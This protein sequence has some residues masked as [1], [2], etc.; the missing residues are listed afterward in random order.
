MERTKPPNMNIGYPKEFTNINIKSKINDSFISSKTPIS[1]TRDLGSDKVAK[2]NLEKKEISPV[3]SYNELK[4]KAKEKKSVPQV[5]N[6][7]DNILK[8]TI[9]YNIPNK[10]KNR[11]LE[12][13]PSLNISSNKNNKINNFDLNK[14]DKI[15]NVLENE[16]KNKHFPNKHNSCGKNTTN[17][18]NYYKNKYNSTLNNNDK[19]KQI[20]INK[21]NKNSKIKKNIIDFNN[22]DNMQNININEERSNQIRNK[23]SN[24]LNYKMNNNKIK[25]DPNLITKS[26]MEDDDIDDRIPFKKYNSVHVS[27]NN[28]YN[29]N[30]S[31][32]NNSNFQIKNKEKE[33]EWREKINKINK[34]KTDLNFNYKKLSNTDNNFWKRRNEIKDEKKLV[35]KYSENTID[36]NIDLKQKIK[37]LNSAVIHGENK[38]KKMMNN[39]ADTNINED[40]KTESKKKMSILGFLRAFKDMLPPLN[41]RKK[42]HKENNDNINNNENKTKIDLKEKF[43]RSG[44]N[45]IKNNQNMKSNNN[46]KNK[47]AD[48]KKEFSPKKITTKSINMYEKK[49]YK[50]V[51]NKNDEYNYYSD[52]AYDSCPV[53]KYKKNNNIYHTP[54]IDIQKN[55]KLVEKSYNPQILNYSDNNILNN[56]NNINNNKN[57]E[58]NRIKSESASELMKL[59]YN[60]YKIEEKQKENNSLFNIYGVKGNKIYKKSTDNN[61]LINNFYNNITNPVPFNDF[62]YNSAYTKKTRRRIY[63][64]IQTNQNENNKYSTNFMNNNREKEIRRY[65][66]NNNNIN[67]NKNN[68]IIFNSI[69]NENKNKLLDRQKLTEAY[70]KDRKYNSENINENLNIN[71]EKKIQEIKI[72]INYKNNINNNYNNNMNYDLNQQLNSQYT[73]NNMNNNYNN[74]INN[75]SNN[76]KKLF[77][78]IDDFLPNPKPKTEIES[79]VINFKQNKK[80]IKTYEN[81]LYNKT[82]NQNNNNLNDN[83][84]KTQIDDNYISSSHRNIYDINNNTNKIYLKPNNKLSQMN[85]LSEN[86]FYSKKEKILSSSGFNFDINNKNFDAPK[87]IKKNNLNKKEKIVNRLADS[88]EFDNDT[89]SMKS[90]K[91]NDELNKTAIFPSSIITNSI[92]SKPFKSFFSYNKNK[93]NNTTN[94]SFNNILYEKKF[95][96]NNDNNNNLNYSF[97]ERENNITSPGHEIKKENLSINFDDK[98][99]DNNN[100]SNMIVY[101]NKR[102]NINNINN[103]N[104]TEINFNQNNS[105]NMNNNNSILSSGQIIYTKKSKSSKNNNYLINNNLNNNNNNVIAINNITPMNEINNYNIINNIKTIIR[106]KVEQKKLNFITK[107]YS[108]YLKNQLKE[109]KYISKEYRKL[110]KLPLKTMSLCTKY[111]YK[112]IQKPTIKPNYIEKKRLKSSVNLPITQNC[113][114]TKNNIVKNNENKIIKK[115]INIKKERIK[116]LKDENILNKLNKEDSNNYINNKLNIFNDYENQNKI[117][118]NNINNELNDDKNINKNNEMKN[119]IHFPTKEQDDEIESPKFGSKSEINAPKTTKNKII[120]IEIQLNNSDKYIKNNNDINDEKN[121]FNI[122]S[123]NN[124]IRLNTQD[125]LYIKKKPNN[126]NISLQQNIL[127]K[128]YYNLTEGDKCKTYIKKRKKTKDFGDINSIN[129]FNL[130]DTN[131]Y[132]NNNIS[133]S[134]NKIISIDIDLLKEQKKIQEEN[135]PKEIK[136]IKA[137]KK[138]TKANMLSLPPLFD[139]SIN[140][141]NKINTIKI[142]YNNNNLNN[143]T[144]I[145]E[146]KYINNLNNDKLKQEIIIKLDIITENNFSSIVE[147]LLNLLTT[148]VIIESNNNNFNKIR[149]SFMEILKNE[150]SFMKIIIHKAIYEIKKIEIYAR[151]CYELSLRLTNEN[152]FKGNETD[153]DLKTI[154]QEECKLKFEEIILGNN[155]IDYNITNFTINKETSKLL[156]IIMFIIELTNFRVISIDIGILC[157]EKLCHKYNDN[158]Y[159][160]NNIYKYYYLDIIVELL[161]KFGKIV[162]DT[163]NMKYLEEIEN[164][165]EQDLNNLINNDM[166]MPENLRNKIMN[167][168]K[169]KKNNWAF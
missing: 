5:Q 108:Y 115:Y 93:N 139:S 75:N 48:I 148:K 78:I 103:L 91:S 124:D 107:Y 24:F 63:S 92:Y 117:Q 14:K 71:A 126:N 52:T 81:N 165:I 144:N 57:D 131:Y 39:S 149:L 76:D 143:N 15:K 155:Y 65:D 83:Y 162:Y 34:Q 84:N 41:L 66:F 1:Y 29:Y 94:N 118:S 163:K 38:N 86:N 89:N 46:D 4:P 88:Q 160:K 23:K 121:I 31:L 85:S 129:N 72:N 168:L 100:N 50:N 77:T 19:F 20:S 157:F 47:Y 2:K 106:P 105:N 59:R 137:Y 73:N 62:N 55:N 40:I 6:K 120:S 44:D 140:S 80:S 151:V 110:F 9:L 54:N 138:P 87:P 30:V 13:I 132:P 119:N 135:K 159:G 167:L 27:I 113:Y 21:S 97:T 51:N 114:F 64:P 42:L 12:K 128:N 10:S 28:N 18:G 7:T 164:Y 169:I 96:N 90:Q 150:T 101:F 36:D 152:D 45:N 141:K 67:N 98:Y 102:N 79:C 69:N 49:N 33:N 60:N 16:K 158:L 104:K 133:K 147:E 111:Y 11:S 123:K 99:P 74:I 35:N 127:E 142:K 26:D 109:K 95:S 154:L 58:N 17:Y 166:A 156:G 146:R 136:E 116:N 8:E 122:N 22:M 125:S 25:M 70:D 61:N 37:K 32:G 161:N 43:N 130:D 56:N 112:I 53:Q 145:I 153:E 134:N 82:I 3:Q 68:N